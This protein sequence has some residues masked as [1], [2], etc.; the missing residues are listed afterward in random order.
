MILEATWNT[1]RLVREYTLLLDPPT[2][3]PQAAP[4]TQ[5]GS[6][7]SRCSRPRRS[8]PRRSPSRPRR[9]G[10]RSVARRRP[11]RR[12]P[13]RRR[14]C[15]RPSP[16]AAARSPREAPAARPVDAAD[17]AS[18]RSGTAATAGT[19]APAPA[20]G[21]YQVKL[22]DTLTRIAGRTQHRGVSLDQML[23]ALYRNNPQAFIGGNIDRLRAG[24]VLAVPS[25]EQAASLASGGPRPTLRAQSADFDAYRDKLGRA[26][27]SVPAEGSPR[28]AGGRVQG[29]VDDRRQP[30]A[31]SD[32][33]T[34]SRPGAWATSPTSCRPGSARHATPRRVPPN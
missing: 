21:D 13:A 16:L 33:L 32:R 31:G 2:Q 4:A 9:R 7:P 12:S 22:G 10:C 18:R 17:A 24:A 29:A 26:A 34:L 28:Q 5:A 3:R 8:S 14:R 19:A 30:A 25:A 1:G 11:G 6:I 20:G 23:T 15:R 27:P